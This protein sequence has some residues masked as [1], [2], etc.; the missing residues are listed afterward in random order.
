VDDYIIVCSD[1]VF[2]NLDPEYLGLTPKDIASLLA[3]PGV[4]ASKSSVPDLPLTW[5]SESLSQANQ[6]MEL[7]VKYRSAFLAKLLDAFS[8]KVGK[9]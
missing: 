6:L 2:N 7:K 4:G 5:R 8:E 9:L 1:G 3:K